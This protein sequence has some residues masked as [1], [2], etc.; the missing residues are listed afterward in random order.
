MDK[1]WDLGGEINIHYGDIKTI[2]IFH[3]KTGTAFESKN[4]DFHTAMRDSCL[5]FVEWYNI[6]PFVS[7]N[8][9]PKEIKEI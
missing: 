8:H 3:V 7:V 2:T 1:I 6:N 5:Q 4:T 9:P